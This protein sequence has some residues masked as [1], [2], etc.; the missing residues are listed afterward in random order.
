MMSCLHSPGLNSP[1]S[2][3]SLRCIFIVPAVIACFQSVTRI[4]VDC[5][6]VSLSCPFDQASLGHPY[7]RRGISTATRFLQ[8]A[9]FVAEDANFVRADDQHKLRRAAVMFRFAAKADDR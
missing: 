3:L 5:R 1:S 2:V 7:S 4:A 8:I 9:V 6:A